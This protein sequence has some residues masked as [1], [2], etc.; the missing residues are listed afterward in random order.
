M[1]FKQ[2]LII[3]II[4]VVG[5]LYFIGGS[6]AVSEKIEAYAVEK[7]DEE[8]VQKARLFNIKYM[9][10]TG[11]RDRALEYANDYLK[12]YDEPWK[13]QQR[14]GV[15]EAFFLKAKIIDSLMRPR[16]AAKLFQEYCERFP[17][18]KKIDEAKQKVA[19]YK[20]YL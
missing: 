7:H 11:K 10:W 12:K 2:L 16:E 19:E 4:I 3:F 1:V 13:R 6:E 14:P 9:Y 20:M 15:D 5:G 18:G 17:E 8:G